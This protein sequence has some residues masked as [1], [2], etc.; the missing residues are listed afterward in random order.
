[1]NQSFFSGTDYAVE[2]AGVGSALV[3]IC[4]PESDAFLESAGAL[5]GGMKLVDSQAIPHALRT[6]SSRPTIVAG[7]SACNTILGIGK[8]GATTRFIGKRGNDEWGALFESSLRRHNVE[9][10]LF[11]SDTPTGHVLSIITPDAQ[12]SMLTYLGASAETL[13][14]QITPSLFD[15]TARSTSKGIFFSTATS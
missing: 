8:L 4:L 3:D 12:R 2:V 7:G 6:T 10:V 15:K 5:K 13:P 1:M 9:P 11:T 14:A